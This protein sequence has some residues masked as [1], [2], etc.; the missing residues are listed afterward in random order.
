MNWTVALCPECAAHVMPVLL[1]T[2][3]GSPHQERVLYFAIAR[4]LLECPRGECGA[5]AGLLKLGPEYSPAKAKVQ[6]VASDGY[7]IHG[8]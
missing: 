8:E 4:K 1:A 2:P 3:V 6:G 7:D 5:H